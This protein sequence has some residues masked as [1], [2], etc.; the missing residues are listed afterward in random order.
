MRFALIHS[1]LIGPLTWRAVA[2][3]LDRAG[4]QTVTPAL[5]DRGPDEGPHWP[6]HAAAA[7]AAI[8]RAWGDAPPILVGH[9]GAG[10]LLPAIAARLA[11]P[12]AAIFV[13]A[14]V[15]RDGA[16][17]LDLIAEEA[18]EWAGRFAAHLRA[19]GRYPEWKEE[20]L[21]EVIPDDAL[22][23]RLI[24]EV[25]P[26]ALDFY[27]EPLPVPPVWDRVPRGMVQFSD[28]YAVPAAS[29]AAAGWPVVRLQGAH[30]HMLVAPAAVATT[31]VALG[32]RLLAPD[33]GAPVASG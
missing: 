20:E 29:A 16:S 33:E 9:S 30:F 15:P 4:H 1:P 22:R 26:R 11:A 14:G 28:A 13:D 7:A 5:V 27:V 18:P 23:R 19:G 8:R 24:A 2:A 17:R 3:E 31:L 10:P 25:Q 32:R 6:R 12:A 21:R